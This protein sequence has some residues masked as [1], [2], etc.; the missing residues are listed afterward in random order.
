MAK[1]RGGRRPDPGVDEAIRAATTELVLQEGF[2]LTYDQVARRAGVGRTTVFRR[3]PTKHELLVA[4]AEQI[5][6]NRVEVPDTG[7]LRGDLNATVRTVYQLFGQAPL[8][9]LGR[10]LLASTLLE[11]PGASVMRAVLDR[12]LE[13]ITGVLQRAVDRGELPDTTGSQLVADLLSGVIMARMA[14]GM[15]LPEEEQVAALASAM[16]VAAGGVEL[17]PHL[18]T[19][20]G[21]DGG[22]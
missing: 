15:P 9:H 14:T 13:L 10:H 4:A 8:Q 7:S 16:T 20:Q 18:A 5:T 17:P 12:R 11:G 21:G 1:S 19:S 22:I 6:I 3:Y 2:D